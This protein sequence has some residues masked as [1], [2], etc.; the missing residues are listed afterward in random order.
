M[1]RSSPLILLP[2]RSA[3][4]HNRVKFLAV[5]QKDVTQLKVLNH[6]R[7]LQAKYRG[8]LETVP[9]AIVM[10]NNMGRIILVNGQAEALFDYKREE[11]LG[12]PIETLLPKRFQAEHAKHRKNYI[13]EPKTRTMGAGLELYASKSD[14]TEFP[15]EISLSPLE[16]E[17]GTFAMSAIR[18]ITDRKKAQELLRRSDERFRLLV[19]GVMDYGIFMLDPEGNVVSWNIGAQRISGYRAEEIIGQH[20]S[21]FYPADEA[22][23]DK[24]A[25]ELKIAA[26]EGRVEHE[27]WHVRQNGSKFW[28]NVVIT[29]LRDNTGQLTGFSKVVRDLTDN[30]IAEELLQ[31]QNQRVQEASRLK[32][33]FLANMSHE[34]RTPLN[35]II[36]FAELMVDGRVGAVSGGT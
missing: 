21:V 12:K 25:C 29:A 32:S 33:Q 30:K 15:V 17:E 4:R 11:L 8:L 35:G 28:A 16:T 18:D 31:E 7:A 36:G 22:K 1:A 2:R 6:G 13:T 24:P 23:S 9:D 14:G 26:T 27:G 5:N 34:L 3:T 10:V 19:T 20:F